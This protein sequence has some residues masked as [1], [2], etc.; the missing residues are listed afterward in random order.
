VSGAAGGG[1][2]PARWLLIG[3]SRWHWA[4]P[5][6]AAQ[7]LEL[8]HSAPARGPLGEA[9]A[10]LL[11]WAAVGSVPAGA[12]LAPERRLRLADVP[13]TAAPPW[14][15]IDRALAG[16]QAWRRRGGAV[17][18]AD[19]GTVVSLSRVDRSGAFAGGR[20]MAG[21]ALQWRAMAA[22]TAALPPLP[23]PPGGEEMPEG[24]AW[25][26]ATA[27]AMRSGVVRGLA[28]AVAEAWE[29]ALALEPDCQLVLTGG[30]GPLLL[31][32]LRRRGP[33]AGGGGVL[34]HRPAL[35]LE[36]LAA[37]VPDQLS[38]RS[39]RI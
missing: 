8:W 25:P 2:S 33:A 16:W 24:E 20:L 34:E 17:L 28:A 39:A 13:L 36:G 18:V 9:T 15:G 7:E 6:A 11:A 31:E 23:P 1:V 21:V 22:G 27:A 14:L 12:G 26:L 37:L 4:A 10:Q 19:A 35:A 29:A 5:G 32:P 3:N 38:P 30:D